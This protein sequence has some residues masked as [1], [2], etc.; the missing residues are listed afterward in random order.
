ME[1]PCIRDGCSVATEPQCVCH[2]PPCTAMHR[3]CHVAMA[4][5]RPVGGMDA[6]PCWRCHA[7]AMNSAQSG[8]AATRL[9][10]PALSTY[11]AQG[12]HTRA[13]PACTGG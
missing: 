9:C 8:L 1:L 5:W 11:A 6:V 4:A 12:L 10:C 2:A 13:A 3:R 7:P